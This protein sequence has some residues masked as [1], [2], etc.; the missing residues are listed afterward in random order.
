MTPADRLAQVRKYIA[1]RG[2]RVEIAWPQQFR[3]VNLEITSAC[4]LK[5]F[6]CNQFKDDDS[7]SPFW[8]EALARYKAEGPFEMPLYGGEE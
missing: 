1:D 3:F 2:A 4:N 7:V 8:A 5:C 6:A